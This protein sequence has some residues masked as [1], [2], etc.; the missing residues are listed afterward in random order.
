MSFLFRSLTNTG[1]R[2]NDPCEVIDFLQLD[3][4]EVPAACVIIDEK[5]GEGAFGEVYRGVVRGDFN[6]PQLSV[7]LRCKDKPFVA[8]KLLKRTW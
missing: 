8:V 3:D 4:W 7:H 6:S 2:S 5:L 1:P